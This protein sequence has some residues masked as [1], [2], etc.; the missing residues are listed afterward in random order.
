MTNFSG[1][2]E[3]AGADGGAQPAEG[4]PHPVRHPRRRRVAVGGLV[5]LWV[6]VGIL[7]HADVI[8]FLLLAIPFVVAAQLGR[9]APLRDLLARDTQTFARRRRGKLA[10]GFALF[11]VAVAVL[12]S[13]RARYV[14]DGWKALL[15]LV[16]LGVGYLVLRRT[17][18]VVT[19]AAAVVAMA[20]L[21]LAPTLASSRN[22]DPGVLR[23]LAVQEKA[24][25]L[26]GFHDIAVAEIDLHAGQQ[27]RVAGI[28]ATSDTPMEI[29]SITKAM[30]GLLIADAIHRGEVTLS[31]QVS[32]YLPELQGSRAGTVTM[33]ELVTH[34][35]G[36]VNIGRSV[37]LSGIWRAPLGL[38]LLGEDLPA[39]MSDARAGHL[40]TRGHYVYSNLG[41]AIAGQALARAVGMTYP[42]LMRVRLFEPLGM[43]HTATQS[44]NALVGGGKSESGLPEKPWIIHGYAPAGAVVSTTHDLAMF[45]SALLQGTAPGMDALQPLESTDEQN[46]QVGIFWHITRNPS[47]QTI[48]WHN[49]ETGGYTSYIGL[50]RMNGLAVIV[51]SDVVTTQT[52]RLGR[53][54]LARQP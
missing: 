33:Q 21:L 11:F 49:G 53:N 3:P 15:L 34:Q 54:L 43:T 8:G 27:A 18:V 19:V 7:L 17:F 4:A 31:A 45:A 50:D 24:G 52:M 40:A 38:N 28:G 22:G 46:T 48:T 35:A 42:D 29:G 51:L 9:G 30:T 16:L 20:G 39:M 26:A 44:S 5:L 12:F 2:N 10:A 25:H 47:G 36:Y 6:V 41:A 13:V 14:P 23:D 1:Q 32:T 37:I